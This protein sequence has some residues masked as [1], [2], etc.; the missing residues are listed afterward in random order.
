M[1]HW[2]TFISFKEQHDGS[3]EAEEENS[4]THQIEIGHERSFE[5]GFVLDP[6]ESK[7]QEHLMFQSS[8]FFKSTSNN[9]LDNAFT[10]NHR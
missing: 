7:E 5:A 9:I 2:N 6:Q 8:N 1:I 4:L 10:E 3:R